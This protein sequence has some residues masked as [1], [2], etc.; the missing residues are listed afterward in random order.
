MKPGTYKF[1][2]ARMV[3]VVRS[4]VRAGALSQANDLLDEAVALA[5]TRK[6]RKARGRTAK[7]SLTAKYRVG[8]VGGRGRK[9]IQIQGAEIYKAAKRIGITPEQLRGGEIRVSHR[10]T[11]GT[12]GFR[13]AGELRRGGRQLTAAAKAKGVSLGSEAFREHVANVKLNYKSRNAGRGAVPTSRGGLTFGGFL[14]RNI[15]LEETSDGD[16]IR[17]TV[18]SKAP[19]SRYVEFPTHRTAAQPFMLPA[20]KRARGSYRDQLKRSWS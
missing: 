20:L 8:G 16:T 4:R 1:D 6:N 18:R 9:A 15:V 10:Q 17:F 2:P 14:R 11:Q 5:P 3:A 7:L 19:Y 13:T 12:P